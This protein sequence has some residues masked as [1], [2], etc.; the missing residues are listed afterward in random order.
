MFLFSVRVASQEYYYSTLYHHKV[1]LED[2]FTGNDAA[3]NFRHSE[4]E[5]TGFSWRGYVVFTQ[6]QVT[7]ES[8]YTLPIFNVLCL[9]DDERRTK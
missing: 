5:F 9:V 6:S 7:L 3:A 1:E 4:S 2:G 8:L